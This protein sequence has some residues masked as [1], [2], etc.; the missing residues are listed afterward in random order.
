[1]SVL[2][3]GSFLA[4]SGGFAGDDFAEITINE[5]A[6]PDRVEG[7]KAWGGVIS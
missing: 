5:L 3:R 1:M 4:S 7:T 2:P 6:G